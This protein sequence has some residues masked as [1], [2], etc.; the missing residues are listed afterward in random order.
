MSYVLD[1]KG[2]QNFGERQV[3]LSYRP[4]KSKLGPRTGTALTIP[5]LINRLSKDKT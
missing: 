2:G 5:A 1:S 3:G 4:L